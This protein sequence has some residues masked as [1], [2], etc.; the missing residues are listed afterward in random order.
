MNELQKAAK[1]LNSNAP[2]DGV[3]GQERIAYLNPL[4]EEV[5]KSIGGSGETIIPGVEEQGDPDVPSYKLFKWIKK[6]VFDDILGIDDNKTL[7]IK[8]KT[9]L[10][11]PLGKVRDDIL[12][13]DS[14]KTFGI[15]DATWDDLA[16]TGAGLVGGPL[17]SL[18]WTVG[19]HVIENNSGDTSGRQATREAMARNAEAAGVAK[20]GV[21][22]MTEAD[23]ANN[24]A[25]AG[26]LTSRGKAGI[27]DPSDTAK[28]KNL[29]ASPGD[30][31]YIDGFSVGGQDLDAFP[32]WLRDT[33]DTINEGIE[34]VGSNF[35]DMVGSSEELMQDYKD[36]VYGKLR[37]MSQSALDTAGSIYDPNGVE[38]EYRGFQDQ[39]R[40]L[41]DRQKELNT[42][43]AL[44]N[45]G[46]VDDVLGEGDRYADALRDSINS[47]VDYTNRSFDAL[48]DGRVTGGMAQAAAERAAATQEASNNRRLLNR[49]GGG[50]TG[51]DMASRMISA[52]RGADQ[53]GSLASMLREGSEIEAAR[54]ERLA[55]VNPALAEVYGSQANLQNRLRALDYGDQ[56]LMGEGSNLGIDQAVLDDDRN[57][58]DSLINMRLGN[59]GLIDSLGGQA[60]AL[61]GKIAD[62]GLDPL[63]GLI[64]TASPFT[65]T[66]LLPTPVTQYNPAPT[67]GG[68][69]FSWQNTL[70]NLPQIVSGARSIFGGGNNDNRPFTEPTR[71]A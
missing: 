64:R 44:S 49:M 47:Q 59:T 23:I 61:P 15:S 21:G 41:A 70:S 66:G 43:T 20:R 28:I 58:T 69:G 25:L 8:H 35:G 26:T 16:S 67:S 46:F 71:P 32:D 52:Q 30:A 51:Q 55:E 36:N 34:G 60:A 48:Q 40:D 42:R 39:F 27:I 2:V 24:R 3:F 19:D 38:S 11:G 1:L 37:D 45:Q 5:L 65:S 56:T 29:L 7:G 10:G 62:A 9:L 6:K 57:L 22:N 54:N 12:G 18:A 13:I 31:E 53:A 4:E 14:T 63:G 50:G 68:G 17:A 33:G